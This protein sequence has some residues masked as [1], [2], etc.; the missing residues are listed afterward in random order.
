MLTLRAK[1]ESALWDE[2]VMHLIC[3]YKKQYRI[4]HTKVLFQCLTK[5]SYSLILYTGMILYCIFVRI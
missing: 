2:D 5:F 1:M 4:S 3:A